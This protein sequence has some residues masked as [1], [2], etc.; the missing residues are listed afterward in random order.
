ML[1][2]DLF[3]F[4][5]DAHAVSL[6]EAGLWTAVWVALALSF[7]GLI[8]LW[9]GGQ[10]AGEYLAG[11]LIEESLSVDNVFVFALLFAY[12]GVPAAY[13]HRVLIWGVLGAVVFRLT[14][15]V[16]GVALVEHFHWILYVFCVFLVYTGVKMARHQDVEVHP[17]RNPV[18]RVVGRLIPITSTYRGQR[19]FVH[20]S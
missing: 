17:E 6:R 2:L 11:Y 8:W 12:F 5:R 13:Q 15:I 14:F 20:E 3:V 10:A 7:G 4:H 1:A 19:L 18:L 16:A 9:R